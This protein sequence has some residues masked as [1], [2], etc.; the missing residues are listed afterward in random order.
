MKRIRTVAAIAAITTSS[1]I[2]LATLAS[3]AGV[4]SVIAM[5][6]KIKSGE[7]SITYANLP[8]AG[9]LALHPSL[10]NGRMSEKVVGEVALTAGDHRNIKVKLSGDVAAG[11][12][13]WADIQPAKGASKPFTD[14]GQPAEQSF[15]A[16]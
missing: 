3:A 14:A 2:S 9:F 5:N 13:L 1:L 12:K 11:T 8:K 16:L 10:D 6:Q 4:P 15:K 7:V